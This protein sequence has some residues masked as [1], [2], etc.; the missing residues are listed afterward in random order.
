MSSATLSEALTSFGPDHALAGIFTLPP[1]KPKDI[2]VLL[3]NAGSVSRVGPFRLNTDVARH[4]ARLGFPVLRFDLGGLGDSGPIHI[5]AGQDGEVACIRLA[6]DEFARTQG[7]QQF[8]I[9]GLC[10]GAYHAHRLAASDQRVVGAVFIDGLAF[11]TPRFYLHRY[12]LRLLKP[13]FWR[14]AIKRRRMA[15][16]NEPSGNAADGINQT[17]FLYNEIIGPAEAAT[18][19]RQMQSRGLKMLFIFT[20]GCKEVASRSQ[21]SEMFGIEP[22]NDIVQVEY[23]GDAE[24]TFPLVENRQRLIRRFGDWLVDTVA[25]VGR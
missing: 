24:H 10:S 20:G 1:V 14:N 12:G 2:G 23:F 9:L 22:D 19:I 11:R 17:Q 18:Q 21:F 3:L 5:D 13:R 16:R 25:P 4:A 15:R 8:V 6:M 7:V